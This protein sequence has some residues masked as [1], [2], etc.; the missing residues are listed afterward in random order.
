MAEDPYYRRCCITGIHDGAPMYIGKGKT[1]RYRVQWHH[2]LMFAGKQVQERE[3]ILPILEEV[4]YK[5]RSRA[6]RD[7]LDY[8]M[9]LRMIVTGKH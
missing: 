3:C 6:V 9:L 8:V 2:N 5:A 7:K 4:H 1:D